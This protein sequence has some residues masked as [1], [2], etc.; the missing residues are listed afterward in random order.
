MEVKKLKCLRCGYQWYPSIR[1][2]G[3]ILI[4]IACRNRKCRS[5]GWFK[6]ITN[7]GLSNAQ[8]ERHKIKKSVKK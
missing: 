4:P 5:V 2:D 3:K 6:P 8:K 1:E 7:H